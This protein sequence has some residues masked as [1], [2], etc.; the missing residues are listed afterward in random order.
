[1]KQKLLLIAGTILLSAFGL[2]AQTGAKITG[3]IK[4]AQGNAVASA[5]ISLF[6]ATDSSFV[7]AEVTNAVGLYEIEQV[8]AG[9][10][11]ITATHTSLQKGSSAVFVV[12]DGES[13]TAETVSLQAA[14]TQLKEVTITGTYKKPMIEVKAD[15]TIFNVESSINATGSNAMELLQKSP[16]VVVDKDDNITMKGK[17][18][19]RIYIDGRATE[20]DTK[21][22]ASYLRSINSVDIEAIEMISNPSAKYD[23][24]GNAGIINIKLKKNKKY[25]LNGNFS[26]GLNVG[27]TPKTNSSLG[28]NYRNKKVNLFSNYSNSWGD[29]QNDINLYRIQAD[30]I[31]DQKGTNTNGGWGHNVKAGID[32]YANA[33]NTLGFI[34]TGNFNNNTAPSSSYTLISPKSTGI[35]AKTLDAT[36]NIPSNNSNTNYNFNYRFADTTGREFNLDAN[37]G[38][39]SGRSN[40][41]QPN[42][43]K[44]PNGLVDRVTINAN[45][46]PVNINIFTAKFDYEKPWAKGKLGFGTKYSNVK[47]DNTFDFYDVDG[48][49]K[50]FNDSL[51]NKFIYKENVTAAYINYSRQLNMKWAVQGG[52]RME[53]TASRGTL[54]TGKT[55][56]NDNDVKRDYTDFFPSAALTFNASMKH[57]FNLTYSRRIDR[58]SYQ[59]LN[60]FENKLDELTYQKGNA[61]LKPQ[62]TN[63]IELTHTFLYR[64]NTTIGYSH[65]KDYSTQI[66]D[67]TL[68]TRAF[69]TQKNLA[70]QDIYSINFALPFQITKWWSLFTNINAFHSQYKAKFD[71]GKTINLGVN[72]MNLY[73]QHGFTL[74]D[75][76]SA[77]ISGFYSAPTIWG[78]TFQS[79][80]IGGMDVGV[81]KL[82]FNNK[83]SIKLS[84]TDILRTM[85]WRGISDFGGSYIDANGRWESQQLRMNFT[86]RFG[87]K[88]VKAARQRNTGNEDES[89]RIKSGGGGFGGN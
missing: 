4:D 39:Y 12:K 5:T 71:D 20:M 74:K 75:G 11:Y 84:Y 34:F 52:V 41:Y 32:I 35:L 85:R 27:K 48:G 13:I 17:N 16:G 36:N 82:L 31:Y 3:K 81:Q 43:Y 6:R 8:K 40:S 65:I 87:N 60:P 2:K 23:A 70:S 37:Y 45:N 14:N 80:A 51:S 57:S 76:F 29:N 18:G 15:K 68:K 24:S 22:L 38:R 73:M 46:T 66:I 50:F 62:Y 63:S 86:Y 83:G 26:T 67:T 49:V 79:K 58:P 33:E 30:T 54:A 69:I 42:V 72:S 9:N 28:L 47:T 53:N 10:Y 64:F 56:R 59:D 77:E 55:S 61:F 88:Q 21:S 19:I 1:M 44:F 89:K 25:G 7:K 78:G